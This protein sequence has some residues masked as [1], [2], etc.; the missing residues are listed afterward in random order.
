MLVYQKQPVEPTP[1]DKIKLLL[2]E[3]QFAQQN[4]SS[5]TKAVELYAA[6]GITAVGCVITLIRSGSIWAGLTLVSAVLPLFMLR[7]AKPRTKFTG[8]VLLAS[9]LLSGTII[10]PDSFINPSQIQNLQQQ[11]QDLNN[12]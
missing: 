4:Q 2:L 10:K 5:H 12:Q 1:E 9:T 3:Q 11:T 6:V 8:W 7:S